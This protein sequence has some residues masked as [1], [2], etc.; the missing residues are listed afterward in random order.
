MGTEQEKARGVISEFLQRTDKGAEGWNDETELWG[1]GLGLD[2]L[3]AAELSAMLEDE[4]GTDPF[5]AGGDLPEKVGDVLAFY[6]TV[7]T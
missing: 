3:E 1:E 4:F 5:S 2:S 6:A 7:S